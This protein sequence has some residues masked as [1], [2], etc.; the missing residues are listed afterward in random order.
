[1]EQ[2]LKKEESEAFQLKNPNINHV[3]TDFL[4]HLGLGNKTHD[5]PKM[6]GDVKVS[7][8]CP[9]ASVIKIF[10]FSFYK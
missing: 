7:S 3:K 5:L 8:F 2:K 6:F 4:H 9:H 10:K 1:M